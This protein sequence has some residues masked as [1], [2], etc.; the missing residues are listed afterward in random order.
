MALIYGSLA[1]FGVLGLGNK[2]STRFT[3]HEAFYEGPADRD[4]L[5]RKVR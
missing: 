4:Q 5:Y 3:S 1:M 2:E